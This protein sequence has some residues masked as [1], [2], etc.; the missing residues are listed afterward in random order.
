MG[1]GHGICDLC[2]AS[3]DGVLD[4]RS[5]YIGVRLTLVHG[6]TRDGTGICRFVFVEME[7]AMTSE[8]LHVL[9]GNCCDGSSEIVRT[10]KNPKSDSMH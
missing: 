4:R 7:S 6:I 5:R 3:Q 1:H 10:A 2:D 8:I 9:P